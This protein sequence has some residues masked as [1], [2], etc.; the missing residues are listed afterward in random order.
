MK[1]LEKR[2]YVY[3]WTSMPLEGNYTRTNY[4]NCTTL[5]RHWSLLPS[6]PGHFH[7]TILWTRHFKKPEQ[8]IQTKLYKFKEIKK[9]EKYKARLVVRG[10]CQKEGIDYGE[11]FSP[12][13]RYESVR[14]KLS[15][16]A[17]YIMQ[18]MQFY[19][20]TAFLHGTLEENIYMEQL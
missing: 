20:K 2:S 13:A 19:V 3:H 8:A 5:H 6:F 17:A 4:D 16:A 12:V 7:L 10:C 18:T 11:I 1:I 14:I 9:I 15:I